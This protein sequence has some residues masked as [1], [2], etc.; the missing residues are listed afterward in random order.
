M[1][2]SKDVA[3]QTEQHWQLRQGRVLAACCEVPDRH[4]PV[5][6]HQEHPRN[7]PFEGAWPPEQS[8][9]GQVSRARQVLIG[10]AFAPRNSE[11]LST[12]LQHPQEVLDFQPQ[13]LPTVGRAFMLATMTALRKDDGGVW[14]IA[15]GLAFRRLVAKCL[16]R[17][18]G[19]EVEVEFI[20][21]CPPLDKFSASCASGERS[22]IL[23]ALPLALE[24]GR[25]RLR[26]LGQV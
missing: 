4:F 1:L 25:T 21:A 3:A 14:G 7:K 11:T 12:D 5:L 24:T 10:A 8:A 23:G 17:Q 20:L 9:E 22:P 6:F 18:F 15:T 19:K 13:C 26:R 2:G 16:T